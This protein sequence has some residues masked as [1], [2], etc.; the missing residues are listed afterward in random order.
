MN[1]ARLEPSQRELA[2]E[3]GI[4]DARGGLTHSR[5][6]HGNIVIELGPGQTPSVIVI[7]RRNWKTVTALNFAEGREFHMRLRT[8]GTHFIVY[9]SMTQQNG[10]VIQRGRICRN[11]IEVERAMPVLRAELGLS[12]KGIVKR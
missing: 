5:H 1:L 2:C 4:L 3:T 12:G 11:M 6:Q 8:N 10:Q 9:G 7:P